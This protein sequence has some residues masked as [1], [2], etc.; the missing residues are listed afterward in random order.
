LLAGIA[1]LFL[2][3][4]FL[5][6]KEIPAIP[7]VP[8]LVV[9]PGALQPTTKFPATW[10]PSTTPIFRTILGPTIAD[11]PT[12]TLTQPTSVQVDG[13]VPRDQALP[14]DCESN[15]ATL[16]AGFLGYKIDEL[17]FQAALPKSDNP[18]R[19]FVGDVNGVWGSLPPEAYGAHASPVA[20]T[21]RS[22]HVPVLDVYQYSLTSLKRQLTSGYP[23][24]A[25]VVG[26]VEKGRAIP[27]RSF[28]GYVTYVAPF[29]HTVLVVGF[30]EAGVTILDNL[31]LYKRSYKE[32]MDS[33]SVLGY[34]AII[35]YP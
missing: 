13:I 28:D 5:D 33:W 29:E 6:G 25:W 24:I 34:M 1:V 11:S 9:L 18:N 22:Y 35:K 20:I 19:G 26:H 15:V 21:L 12:P 32:F 31:E 30:D 14:L 27:W 4:L 2:G 7:P 16:L 17:K 8:S 23:V 3:A 10:T